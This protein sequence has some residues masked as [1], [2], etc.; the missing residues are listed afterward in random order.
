MGFTE[1]GSDE[2][3]GRPLQNLRSSQRRQR[4]RT[5]E[6]RGTIASRLPGLAPAPYESLVMS[7]RNNLGIAL[8]ALASTTTIGCQILAGLT[9]L[10][11]RKNTSGSTVASGGGQGGQ[12]GT[13]GQAGVGGQ[14]GSP[15]TASSSSA[16][17]QGGSM[18]PLECTNDGDCDKN[19]SACTEG[20]CG[21]DGTCG[22]KNLAKGTSCGAG[23]QCDDGG[24]CVEGGCLDGQKGSTETDVDCGGVCAKKCAN[25]KGCDAGIDCSDGFCDTSSPN[26]NG[27]AGT[28]KPCTLDSQCASDQFCQLALGGKC[29]AK[30][31]VG[32][33]CAGPNGCNSG[34]CVDGVCCDTACT[35]ACQACSSTVEPSLTSGTCGPRAKGASSKGDACGAFFCDGTAVGCPASCAVDADCI[36][37]GHCDKTKLLCDNDKAYGQP[38]T[39]GNECVGAEYCVDATCCEEMSCAVGK[40]CKNEQGKCL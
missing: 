8:L 9:D 2:V 27:S 22:T 3:N 16:G 11:P 30:A 33:P 6:E 10:K 40:S 17:G 12:G 19:D 35:G 1:Y 5:P 39:F 28:C 26:A 15:D 21:G 37:D 29:V 24:N 32:V 38:C 23:K 7:Y 25:N 4:G 20:V 34:F 13:G 31:N 18:T 36:K 14:G